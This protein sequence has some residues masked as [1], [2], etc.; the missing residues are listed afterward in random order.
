MAKGNNIIALADY[1]RIPDR[2][3]IAKKRAEEAGED[4]AAY[5]RALAD[6]E[7]LPATSLQGVAAKFERLRSYLSDVREGA[8]LTPHGW[9][10]VDCLCDGIDNALTR[11]TARAA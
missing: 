2:A 5:M 7:T 10:I 3:F 9:D 1:P 11:F 8:Q 4:D 6:L